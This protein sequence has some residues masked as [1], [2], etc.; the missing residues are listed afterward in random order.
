MPT[1]YEVRLYADIAN[2]SR[3]LSS[4][5]ASQK[6][7]AKAQERIARALEIAG[8]VSAEYQETEADD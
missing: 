7:I 5:A 4:I 1:G 6:R 3:E 8:D 2:I